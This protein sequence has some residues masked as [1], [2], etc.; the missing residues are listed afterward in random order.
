M[1]FEMEKI[2]ARKAFGQAVFEL[3][4]EDADIVAVSGDGVPNMGLAEMQKAMPDRVYNIGIAEQNA[5][6]IAAGMAATGLKPY[7]A[8]FAAFVTMRAC[9]QVRTFVCYPNLNVKFAGGMGGLSA[10]V[11]GVTHQATEDL[12]IFRTFP[13]MVLAVPADAESTVAITKK[14]HQHTGPA[15]IRLF[16]GTVYNVFDRNTYQF[17]IGKA[18]LL[19]DGGDAAVIA[20]GPMVAIA[21][22]AWERLAAEGISVRVIEMA[23]VK[24][25]DREA[26]IAASKETGAIVTAED[27]QINGALGSA[28]A[29]VLAEEA[30]CYLKRLGLQDTFGE[31]GDHYALLD[32]YGLGVDSIVG[33]V[34]ET[35]GK[36]L[37]RV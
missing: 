17:E 1:K 12:G 3:A 33:A 36:K 8:G 25:I 15:Y 23:C 10:N 32:K 20:N 29:E 19:K 4:K 34:K 11:E 30:P 7:V 5:T 14:L 16:K 6:N 27:H 26:V 9:E 35:I 21:L 22:E 37:G 31:S 2:N 18:N 24:P 13:N 28:V